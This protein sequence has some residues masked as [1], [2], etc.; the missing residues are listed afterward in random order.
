MKGLRKALLIGMTLGVT[1]LGTIGCMNQDSASSNDVLKVGAISFA[2]TL[3]PTENYFSWA[4]VRFGVGET[5]IKFDDQMKATPWLATSWK[6]G[7]DKL[8]WTFTINDKVK[9]SNGKSLTAEAVKASLERTFAKS[10]RAKT[11]FNYTEITA[12]G[13]ELTIKTDKEYYNLP[14]LLGDPLFLIMDVTAEANG[15]D[16]AKEGPIGTGPYVVSSFTKERAELKRNDNYWDGKAGFAKVEIPSINDANT[17]AMAL[18]SGDVL[19]LENLRYHNEETKNDPEFAKQLASLAD[20]AIN[21]AFGVSHRNAASVVGIADYIP[22]VAGFLL[23][24]EIEALSAAVVHPKTPMAAIIGGAKVTDKISVISNLLPKVDVMIIGGGMANA[25]IK[26]QGC[27]IGSSLFEEGQEAIATD[28]VMEARV[29]GAKLLTPIDAVVAD[30][31]SN[32][33]NTKIVDVD[34]I[35]DGW[36][37]LDIGPKTRELYIEALAPMKTIIWN[38]PMGVFEMENFAAGTNAVAKAVAE[39]DAMTIVGGGDSVAAIEKSGLADKISH[40]STG[41]GASLEFL[42][43]KIL[44]GI[45]ALSEA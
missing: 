45:A 35:E 7:D 16:I 17:R 1:M 29:A 24:K 34:Q 5:L 21:D 3:E 18:Q 26:A 13:Q 23:K 33:A 27:N 4:V 31:F 14:N 30:A 32:D 37:I 12:N 11:F 19:M 43:G 28:L 20:V 39:S 40:I 9:F 22:M 8:T 36:M 6:Q 15:R 44:P 2:G 25:F 38:G 41:G 42:E 10:K